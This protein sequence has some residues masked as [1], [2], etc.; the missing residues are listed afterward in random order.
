MLT[1]FGEMGALCTEMEKFLRFLYK[2]LQISKIFRNF[3][4]RIVCAHLRKP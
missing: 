4:G 2:Y 1:S 3:V